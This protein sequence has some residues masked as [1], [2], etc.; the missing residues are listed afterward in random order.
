MIL[1]YYYSGDICQGSFHNCPIR[2]AAEEFASVGDK[3]KKERRA[4]V[5]SGLRSSTRI[6]DRLSFIRPEV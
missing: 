1:Y 2:D 4:T 5:R 6:M 3:Y